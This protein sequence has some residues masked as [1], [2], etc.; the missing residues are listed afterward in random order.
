[1]KQ[2]LEYIFALS[3]SRCYYLGV[4]EHTYRDYHYSHR[5]AFLFNFASPKTSKNGN[6]CGLWI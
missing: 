5:D 6:Q 4:T 3:I 1:M 2:S